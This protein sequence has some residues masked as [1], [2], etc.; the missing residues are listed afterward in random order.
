ME[1]KTK[2]E[3][4]FSQAEVEENLPFPDEGDSGFLG[5]WGRASAREWERHN[6]GKLSEGDRSSLWLIFEMSSRAWAARKCCLVYHFNVIMNE[7]IGRRTLFLFFSPLFSTSLCV[8]YKLDIYFCE[9]DW[10]DESRTL[11]SIPWHM[12]MASV[13]IWRRGCVTTPRLID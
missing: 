4:L 9:L 11:D 13:Q 2:R 7:R 6:A 5:W 10:S 3:S 8:I 12:C 1:S